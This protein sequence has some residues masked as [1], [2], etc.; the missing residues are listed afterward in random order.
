MSIS[1]QLVVRTSVAGLLAGSSAVG[2]AMCWGPLFVAF[3]GVQ[4]PPDEADGVLAALVDVPAV[5]V[6]VFPVP[7]SLLLPQP[8]ARRVRRAAVR[9]SFGWD[10]GGQ[11]NHGL[12]D[13]VS[14][15]GRLRPRAPGS[16]RLRVGRRRCHAPRSRG[17]RR[18][19]RGRQGRG[20]LHQR[21]AP[22]RG[23]VRPEALG[24]R[25]PRVD[26]GGRH[27]R[28]GAPVRPGIDP[29]LEPGVRDRLR[30]GPTP[31]RGRR[32]ARDPRR[33][34]CRRPR[35]P[36]RLRLRRAA[37]RGAGDPRRGAGAVHLPRRHVPDARRAVARH[38]GDRRRGR[39]CD[40][41]RGGHG[42]QA[43]ARYLRDGTGPARAR[44]GA[45]DRRQG[46]CRP[47]RGARSAARRRARR[48]RAVRRCRGVRHYAR[49][50][51]ARLIALIVNPSAGGGRA[52][53][54]LPKVQER[55]RALGVEHHTELT[56]DL[57][58][59]QD[60]ARAAAGAG[61]PAVVLSG[62]GLIGAIAHVLRGHPG[63]VMGVLPGGRGNDFA[64]VAGIPLDAGAACEVIAHGVPQDVDLGDVDGAT[65]IGIAS[66]GFDSEANR[67]ANEAPPQLG[68]MVYAYGALRALAGWKHAIFEVMVDGEARAFS[69][70]TVACANSKAYGGGMFMA[71]D[72]ELDDGKLDVVMCEATSKATFLRVLP[73]VFKGS[74]VHEP[75]YHVLRGSEVRISA[76][77]PFTVYADGDP[78][79]ELPC[80]VRA[81]PAAVK[82]LLP[83]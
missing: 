54:A 71:P 62:D 8:A 47:R 57:A 64:R 48:R 70:W 13:A 77:R 65:F 49:A 1:P 19:A 82:V 32:A 29:R 27:G 9:A 41:R 28:G 44:P 69:G 21:R 24:T 31:C 38:R 4:G 72:A 83:A 6:E 51:G 79:G 20:V 50:P 17:R 37:L 43:V 2:F 68:G 52:A 66:L 7:V 46:G 67:I 58:H 59:A 45:R 56:R 5:D 33:R 61:E 12:R 34:R 55:L 39:S 76:D 30:C 15:H 14:P 81:I 42:R 63:A 11:D 23:G 18:A 25:L 3:A 75:S 60:L 22:F 36:R 53:K 78:I 40:G 35:R 26:R 10:M 73:K 16:R 80:T 74:H